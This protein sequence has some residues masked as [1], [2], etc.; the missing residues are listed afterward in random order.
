MNESYVD[1]LCY[2]IEKEV[3]PYFIATI[4]DNGSEYVVGV[5]DAKGYAPIH[6]P[7]TFSYDLSKKDYYNIY[8]ADKKAK[9]ANGKVIFRDEYFAK[10]LKERMSRKSK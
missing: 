5:V 8:D 7:F 3:D 4:V 2:L 1:M 9:L 6:P 10:L